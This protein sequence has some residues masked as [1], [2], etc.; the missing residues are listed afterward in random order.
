M[1]ACARAYP[2]YWLGLQMFEEELRCPVCQAVADT[3]GDHQVECGGNSDRILHNSLQDVLFSAAHSRAGAS[4]A[5]MA[6]PTFSLASSCK[7]LTLPLTAKAASHDRARRRGSVRM[8]FHAARIYAYL[9]THSFLSS[10]LM[11][12][13]IK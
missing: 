12:V 3:H 7:C 9:D 8:I 6:A 10:C 4:G 5:A 2:L 11:C 13:S 1:C